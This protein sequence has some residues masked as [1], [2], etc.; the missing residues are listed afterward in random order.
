MA[1][2]LVQR[3]KL[4]GTMIQWCPELSVA[5]LLLHQKLKKKGWSKAGTKMLISRACLSSM[6]C[7]LDTTLYSHKECPEHSSTLKEMS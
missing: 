6:S 2:A 1:V 7:C 3:H 5:L 4:S